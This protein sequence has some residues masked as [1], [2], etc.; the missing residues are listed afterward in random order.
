MPYRDFAAV[1]DRLMQDIPYAGWVQYLDL[2]FQKHG[3]RPQVV[4]DIGCG[5][6][7]V[8][9]PLAQM[10]YRLI[11]LDM[12][13][14]MLAL[15]EEKARNQGLKISWL[16]QDMRS[17]NL[18]DLRFDLV[19]SMTDS[20]NYIQTTADLAKVFA[21]VRDSL[22]TGGWFIFD[23]NSA[24]KI[25]EVFGNNVFSLIEDDIAYI[26]ENSYDPDTRTCTM[27]LTFFVQ[28][29]DGRYRRFSEVHRETGFD[30]TEVLR[31]LDLAGFSVEAVY[32]ENSVV[33][34]VN[35]TERIYFITRM[36]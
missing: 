35:D 16:Q 9:I 29:K 12:S 19:I 24:Y 2:I 5:T 14:E 1:Y 21:L 30:T 31:L 28:E 18:G 17:M 20:L 22:K 11:G 15:A 33:E 25:R 27:D 34:P 3:I 23:L 26:W 36:K 32:G 8:T 4:L 7:N 13:Q 10:G 6:G